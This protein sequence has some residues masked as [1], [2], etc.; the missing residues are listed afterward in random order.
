MRRSRTPNPN[1]KKRPWTD[2]DPDF[3]WNF[4]IDEVNKDSPPRPRPAPPKEFG[5][6]H[7]YQ[8]VSEVEHVQQPSPGTSS[9]GTSTDEEFGWINF[10]DFAT[11][12]HPG[13]ASDSESPKEFA[14]QA[15]EYQ[16]EQPNS[17]L[18]ADPDFD[19]NHW[20]NL[21][22]P[23]PS[24]PSES[25]SKPSIPESSN[26]GPSNPGTSNP[27]LPTEPE[28]HPD[29]QSLSA[30]PQMDDIQAAIYAAKGKGKQLRH[31]SGTARDVGNAA[32][33]EL[34]LAC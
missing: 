34:Q 19:W 21:E 24:R 26:P 31:I 16:V 29:D 18:S 4:W 7:E 27:S 33:R 5:Q 11:I 9:P 32:Q 1:P 25:S 30:D 22:D 12:L 17:G 10:D 20:M 2:P 23:P 6:A 15:H 3:D 28:L 14:G 13:P 8:P